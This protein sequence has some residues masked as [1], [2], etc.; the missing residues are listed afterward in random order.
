MRQRI[1]KLEASET[2]HK[3]TADILQV[4][5][6][7]ALQ[8]SVRQWQSTF[9][10]I[11]D[12]V[13]IIDK[14]YRVVRANQTMDKFFDGAKVLDA[15]CYELFHGT[16][17]AIPSCPT[18]QTFR[19]GEATHAELCEQHLGGHWFD[20]FAYPIK[21]KDGTVQQVVHIVRD[22]TERKKAEEELQASEEKYRQV[23]ENANEAILVIQDMVIK[24]LNPKTI[25]ILGYSK[26]EA[27]RESEE[28]AK[29]QYKGIPIPTYTWQR[30]DDDFV[31]IDHNDAAVA[32][33]HGKIA[34]FVGIKASE[35]YRDAP[36][37]QEE[38][39][40]CFSEK[41]SIE[42]EMLYRFKS[43]GEEKYLAV[44]YAFVPPDLV[45]VHT[46]D[47]TARKW[48]EAELR[49]KEQAI[50]SSISGIVLVDLDG[51]IIY[52][53]QAYLDIFAYSSAEE[54]IGHKM[55]EVAADKEIA[56]KLLTATQTKGWWKGEIRVPVRDG[57]TI[58]ILL[59]TNL[60]RNE[61]GVPIAMMASVT[62]ISERKQAEEQ[63]NAS[64]KEKEALLSEIHHRVKNNLQVISSLLRL[65][66]RDIEDEKYSEMFQDSRNRI[67]S[68]ALIHEKLYRSENFANIDFAE[69]IKSLTSDLFRAYKGTG[70]IAFKMDIEEDVSLSIDTAIPCGLIINELVSNSLKHAFPE[71]R[72]G[73][74][75]ISIRSIED[76]LELVVSDNGVGMPQ[77]LDIRKTESLGL[78]LVSIL[79]E[80][81]L[82]G[83]INLDR[84]EGTLF[85]IKFK[86]TRDT[87]K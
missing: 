42:R 8:A 4:Q 28:R 7:E 58:D 49:I 71:G 9:D 57:R 1:T 67:R 31:L 34:D 5:T 68:M 23:V 13:A 11:E 25:E 41:A 65:Q 50:A 38:I 48:A 55:T 2:Q 39:Y 80:G 35:L 32:I 30:V 60:V 18:Y 22:I 83:E 76:E 46:E 75:G 6:E 66:E 19:S 63:L 36:K 3:H 81:Q 20:V 12:L 40:R 70:R 56:Q 10:A 27:L 54:A 15:H 73:E 21:D 37:I 45:L 82:H 53:N 74:I 84:S 87:V 61:K 16:E 51:A 52:V 62:D 59:S 26:E 47:I 78:H 77:N 24:F 17:E 79:A 14:D 29:A 33:T 86:E 44:K 69:Y 72:E 64:L 43:T 85:T